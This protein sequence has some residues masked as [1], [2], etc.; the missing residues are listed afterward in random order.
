MTG[1]IVAAV[2]LGLL[3][4]GGLARPRW[5]A[6]PAE[7]PSALLLCGLGAAVTALAVGGYLA[8]GSPAQLVATAP[9]PAA[10]QARPVGEQLEATAQDLQR[11]LA[12]RPDDAG[13]WAL[14]ARAQA[15]LGRG[16]PAA[17]ALERAA[18]LR[19]QDAGL[20]ADHADFIARLQGPSLA[21]EPTRLLE[22]ALAIDPDHPK[23]LALAGAAAFDRGAFELAA[24][25]W[26]RLA[27]VQQH[28][29]VLAQQV[30]A[31]VEQAKQ[32]AA[33]GGATGA[34]VSGVV[35]LAPGLRARV[36]PDDTLFVHARAVDGPPG[37]PVAV[38]RKQVRD[39]PLQFTL[40]DRHAMSPEVRLSNVARVVIG[41]RISRSGDAMPR[42]GDLQGKAP[43]VA[44]GASGVQ[45]EIG[46]VVG[47]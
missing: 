11:Q 28:D 20:L 29:T 36:A 45:V 21:G 31:R 42:A 39:L 10:A 6:V 23:A 13:T 8:I 46:E 4:L 47:Q 43:T 9:A 27:D 34:H 12:Q 32:R 16:G 7:R 22:R 41:A 44:V 5:S 17:E 38:L 1:F 40:D 19:P 14:L 37:A 26:E 35:T 24:R 3:T 18:A 30:R 15:A 33:G 25:H 2:A